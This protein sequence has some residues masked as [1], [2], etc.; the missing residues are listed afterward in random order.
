MS[1]KGI[2]AEKVLLKDNSNIANVT[3]QDMGRTE[4]HSTPQLILK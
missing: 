1:S 4:L 3:K 2:F